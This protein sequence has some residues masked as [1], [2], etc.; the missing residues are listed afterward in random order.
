MS[1]RQSFYGFHVAACHQ[2]YHFLRRLHDCHDDKIY[3]VF[4][5][6]ADRNIIPCSFRPP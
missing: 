6:Y 3:L 4:V 1:V 2:A 5:D